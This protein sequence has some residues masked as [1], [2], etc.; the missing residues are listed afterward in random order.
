MKPKL[1]KIREIKGTRETRGSSLKEA[2][3]KKEYP[4]LISK[5]LT[6]K[7]CSKRA[8]TISNIKTLKTRVSTGGKAPMIK[9][10]AS[11]TSWPQFSALSSTD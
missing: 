6:S 10:L 8:R 11:S 1:K 7:R 4:T 3:R 9:Q 2:V 5:H